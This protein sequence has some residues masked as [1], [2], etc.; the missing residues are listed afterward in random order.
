MPKKSKLA[1]Y[2]IVAYTEECSSKILNKAKLPTKLK[3]PGNFTVQV[4]IGKCL[5]ARGLCDLYTSIN[6]M[7]WFMFK[8]L[9]LGDPKLTTILLQLA[10]HSVARPNKIIDDVLVQARSL[11]FPVNFVILDLES[12][13]EVLFIM[14]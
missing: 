9:G 5:N 13:L 12:D 14:G 8:K 7:L 11:I 1:E 10:D 4:I 6:L 3:D 2:K